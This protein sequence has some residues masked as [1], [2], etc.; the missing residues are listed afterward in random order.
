MEEN[1]TQTQAKPKKNK[2]RIILVIAFVLLFL[3]VSFIT[4]K[5]SYLE[6]KEL[7]SNY[8]EIFWANIKYKYIIVQQIQNFYSYS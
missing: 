2:I 5:S 8:E 6:F 1:K 3:A 7:G 4:L